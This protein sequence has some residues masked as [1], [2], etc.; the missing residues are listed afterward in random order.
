MGQ[1]INGQWHQD[2]SIKTDKKGAFVRANSSFR[3][4]L[5]SKQWPAEANRYH[6]FVS[7]AC[8]WAHRTLIVRCLKGLESLIS[9]STALPHMGLQGWQFEQD[10]KMINPRARKAAPLHQ[11]Y[12]KS[13]AN[14]TGRAT[15]P[16]LWDKQTQTIVNNE[17]SD[18]MRMLNHAF[19]SLG[20]KTLDLYPEKRRNDIDQI[21][22]FVYEQINNG[23][24]RAGFAQ[25]QEAYEQAVLQLFSALDQ[26]E[27]RL[28]QQPY[29]VGNQCTEAD[30][31]LFPTLIRFDAVYVCHFKTNLKRLSDYPN[32]S[33]YLKKL[34]RAPGIAATVD[35]ATIKQH[36]F[37]SHPWLNPSGLVPVGPELP[38]A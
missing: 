33:R 30:W 13:K 9:V 26:L 15:V 24:Y 6:L 38:F 19:D 11:L 12:R 16:V 2:T 35:F 27:I 21:N 31:R 32:L 36:Y 18:I 29:L 37:T 1:L 7:L 14:F 28:G 17:S 34:Y 10:K 25:S 8:P 4:H 20:A 23:V 3:H 22:D 5:G